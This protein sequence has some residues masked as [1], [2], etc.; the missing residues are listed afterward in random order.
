MLT[1]P[2]E[3]VA[4]RT[5]ATKWKRHMLELKI[6]HWDWLKC[7][8]P[9]S[10]WMCHGHIL[11]LKMFIFDSLHHSSLEKSER[12]CRWISFLHFRKEKWLLSKLVL[13]SFA[14]ILLQP[15]ECLSSYAA[16]DQ[17]QAH[18]CTLLHVSVLVLQMKL[19]SIFS[20][21]TQSYLPTHPP[22]SC[23]R[24]CDI[25]PAVY[26][27]EQKKFLKNSQRTAVHFTCYQVR[28]YPA[29]TK[30]KISRFLQQQ[31]QQ[32][33]ERGKSQ[34][35]VRTSFKCAPGSVLTKKDT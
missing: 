35:K 30:L 24:C 32:M 8:M 23:L 17:G 21:P 25:I 2:E 16:D 1:K 11:V 29:H 28:V 15:Q 9:A 3:D 6:P 34:G 12:P 31:Q 22:V 18:V 14:F 10:K 33:V 19:L 5:D 4:R 27:Q 7:S 26:H 20:H 13:P